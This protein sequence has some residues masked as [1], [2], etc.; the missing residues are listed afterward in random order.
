MNTG[1][2][3]IDFT[4]GN[5]DSQLRRE[6]EEKDRQTRLFMEQRARSIENI[7]AS[8]DEMLQSGLYN[9]Q[10]KVIIHMNRKLEELTAEQVEWNK[11]QMN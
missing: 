10:D 3:M 8:R 6:E 7:R 4:D 9:Q 2:S 11:S 1:K 5:T